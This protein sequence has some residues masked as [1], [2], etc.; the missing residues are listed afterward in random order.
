MA[1]P[2]RLKMLMVV[3]SLCIDGEEADDLDISE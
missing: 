1:R 3:F 2:V